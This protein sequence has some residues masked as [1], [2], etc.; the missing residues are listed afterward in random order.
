MKNSQAIL[1]E[2]GQVTIPK[3]IRDRL[4]L[5]PGQVLEFKTESG[6]LTAQ[7]KGS[8]D[9][10]NEVVGYLRGKIKDVDAY[11]DEIRGRLPERRKP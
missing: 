2:K 9:S 4:G 7:K 5:K 8:H 6:R 10:I 1:S 11:I 3:V